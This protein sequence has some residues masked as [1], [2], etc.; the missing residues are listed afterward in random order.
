VPQIVYCG[1]YDLVDVPAFRLAGVAPGVPI[2]VSDEAAASLLAQ[3]DN[4]QPADAKAPA[5]A[6]A[7]KEG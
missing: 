6:T 5:K 3:P 4:W 2:E 7:V 1:P